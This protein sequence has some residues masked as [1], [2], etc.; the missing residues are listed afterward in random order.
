M[1]K[2]FLATISL[3][4][5]LKSVWKRLPNKS[6]WVAKHLRELGGFPVETHHTSWSTSIGMCN[7][8]HKDGACQT[9]MELWELP[10]EYDGI[11]EYERRS[12]LWEEFERG[13]NVFLYWREEEE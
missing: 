11:Q 1:S 5:N 6:A 8:Y 3:P 12:L 10:T 4:D 2:T 7:M 13:V 9:C